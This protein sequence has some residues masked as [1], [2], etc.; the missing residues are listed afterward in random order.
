[1]IN[2]LKC[3]IATVIFLTT[4]CNFERTTD[5]KIKGDYPPI[6]V[7]SG[8]GDLVEVFIYEPGFEGSLSDES[9]AIWKIKSEVMPGKPVEEVRTV[10]YGVVPEGFKQIVPKNE[11]SPLPLQN[12]NRYKFNFVTGNAPGVKGYFEMKDKKA[13]IVETSH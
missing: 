12:G 9:H 6:F 1:M 8:S 11:E 5:V 3:T 10:T 7:L 4:A 2:R 13:V